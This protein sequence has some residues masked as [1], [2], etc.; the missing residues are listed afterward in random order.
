MNKVVIKDLLKYLKKQYLLILLSLILSIISVISSLYIPVI[1][2]NIID[3]LIGKDLV[4]INLV[5]TLIFRII[6]CII[7]SLFA[8]YFL[9][10]IN[11]HIVYK[12]IGD[13]RYDL[14]SHI[15]NLP[16]KYID[17][18]G[19]GQIEN[20][21][22]N[23]I[24]QASE[25]LLLSFNQFF[26]SITTIIITIFYMFTINTSTT[27]IVILLTPIA[28]IVS[29]F[30]T[31]RTYNLFSKQSK[32]RGLQSEYI[33]EM[34]NGQK[35]VQAYL[36]QDSS[37]K[38]FNDINDDLTNTSIKA[39][40]FSSLVNPSTR[41][42]NGII[43]GIITLNGSLSIIKGLL[44]VGELTS[45]LAYANQYNKPFNEISGI[46]SELQ[47]SFACLNRV[48]DLLKVEK[49]ID[50][51]GDNYLDRVK[52]DVS[53]NDVDFSYTDNPF[54]EDLNINLKK[55][56]RVALVGPTGCG[57]TTIINLLMRFYDPNK[58]N[59]TI[60]GID[61]SDIRKTNL[62]QNIGMILQDTWLKQGTIKENIS[63]GKV[64]ASDE[65]IIEA[66]K[67]G[68][69]H[70]FI[71][72]LPNGYDT[73][74]KENGEGLSQG[75]K[76]LLCISRL[77]LS[78]PPILILDEATSSIDTRTELKI[79]DSFATLMK[80]KTS[81]IVAH[82][83]STIKEADLILVMKDGKIIEKGN[84]DELIKHDGF[85]KELYYS[86]LDL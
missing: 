39:I 25:G 27:L 22:V 32:L 77:M 38:Q 40:F 41:L 67:K 82:R 5:M 11:N 65:E 59:I 85:Y 43:Y 23:D 76:Q 4:N 14:F 10:I 51:E 84:H 19:H 16:I 35:V 44:T 57:K 42:V 29:R 18:K 34:I 46:I 61:I 3:L 86:Q 68:H 30:I 55:G 74:I 75:E 48:F 69:A 45:F 78:L 47:N 81:F 37:Q 56:Q 83:L 13:I 36:Y 79:Q 71:M 62:R 17:S 50:Y 1:I 60:D 28:L 80:N 8:Q 15:Q 58:G 64:D 49:E 73:Y 9:S 6:I 33:E 2:G 52:G 72:R 7:I 66:A 54:I 63:I 70:S 53:F 12:T 20:I 21:A 26:S 31:S 24:D